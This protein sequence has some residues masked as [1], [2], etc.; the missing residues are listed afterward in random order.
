MTMH[1]LIE[2]LKERPKAVPEHREQQKEEWLAALDQLFRSIEE[3]LG[4][5]VSAGVLTTSRS[6]TDV[7]EADLGMYE[8]PVLHISDGRLT[9]RLQPVGVR[10][11]GVVASGGRRHVG[12]RGRV[13]LICGPIKIPLARSGSDVWKAL[14]MRGEPSELTEGSFAE[15]L[16]E[17][18]LDE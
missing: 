16:G 10:V 1:D 9:V 8:A 3:W 2:K 18:L 14:P 15:L 6:S 5:A 13:D 17:V 11:A 12:L 4:P 7:T